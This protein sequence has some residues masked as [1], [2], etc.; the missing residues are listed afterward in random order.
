MKLEK[1][2]K[3]EGTIE[4]VT[5][6][7]IKSGSNEL[8]IGGADSEIV[9]N[10]INGE[11][12][13]PGSSLKGKM[14]SQL[15]KINGMKDKKQ[16]V[17]D[18]NPCGCGKRT[19]DICVLFGAHLNPEAESAPSRLIVRD[20]VMT[21]DTREKVLTLPAERGGYLEVK[22]EN[23]INRKS[24]TAGSPRFIERIPAGLVFTLEVILQIMEGDNEQ[25][26][27]EQVEKALRLVE[28]SYLGGNGSRGYGQVKF[29]GEW[30]D[31]EV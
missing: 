19:C 27:K 29:D 13:I 25:H 30:K 28:N 2:C 21:E 26:L 12:Y 6:L 14:R 15:E 7:A 9:K 10:P 23:T 18:K 22:A 24:G 4:L 3:Y 16:N 20:S 31:I 5:G 17:Q 1:I 8:G 11:P